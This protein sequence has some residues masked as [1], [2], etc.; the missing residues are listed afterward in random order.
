[1]GFVL[2]M[3][4]LLPVYEIVTSC[5]GHLKIIGSL[6][7]TDIPNLD[8]FYFKT[9]KIAFINNITNLI[10]KDFTYWEA[11]K[12]RLENSNFILGNKCCQLFY[13]KCQNHLICFWENVHQMSTKVWIIIVFLSDVV[14]I[15]YGAQ[16]GTG[17][18]QSAA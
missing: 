12:L 13:L 7:F 15:K 3:M 10:R 14:S 8:I 17:L 5:S 6:T 4:N 9:S 16:C 2:W 1:V 18:T 11:V